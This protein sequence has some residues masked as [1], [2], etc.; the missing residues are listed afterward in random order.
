MGKWVRYGALGLVAFL[1]L[2]LAIGWLLPVGHRASRTVVVTA[3]PDKVF[4]IVTDMARYPEWNS[5]VERVEVTGDPGAGQRARLFGSFGEIP[6]VV[7]TFEPPSRLV[8]RIDG[9]DMDFGGTWTYE[10]R[11][12][13]TGTEIT[14]TE[15]GEVYNPFFRFMSR[16][17]FGHHATIDQFLAD[18]VRVLE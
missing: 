13:G 14:I 17:V 3:S 9:T 15:D 2:V 5:A 7:E 16:F 10:L 4:A 18:L 8:T 11:P 12:S 1:V 6:Y